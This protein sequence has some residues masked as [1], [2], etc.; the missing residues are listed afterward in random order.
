MLVLTR[1]QNQ[2]IE[3]DGKISIEVLKIKGNTVRLG[4]LAPKDKKILRGELDELVIDD[5]EALKGGSSG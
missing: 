5:R 1:R 4:I 2:K 3:I